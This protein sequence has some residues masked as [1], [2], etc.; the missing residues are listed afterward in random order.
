M[1]GSSCSNDLYYQFFW[2]S[3]LLPS[4]PNKEVVRLKQTKMTGIA[5]DNGSCRLLAAKH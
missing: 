3:I 1:L 4:T 2:L 5:N